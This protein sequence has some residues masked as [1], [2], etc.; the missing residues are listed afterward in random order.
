MQIFFGTPHR[1]SAKTVL[2]QLVANVAKVA[3]QNPNDKLVEALL[4]DSQ[5]LEHQ[6]KSFASISKDLRLVCL[7]EEIPMA[8][9]M[10]S[11]TLSDQ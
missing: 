2:A 5:V 8:I 1:G 9:G 11:Y 10:V 4:Q 3:L 6:R 7:A